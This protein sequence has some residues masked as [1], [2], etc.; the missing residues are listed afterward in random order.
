[1][2]DTLDLELE[3]AL[4]N[5]FVR[6]EPGDWAAV[7]ARAGRRR[8]LRSVRVA[9]VVAAAMLL[10]ATQALGVTPGVGSLFGTSAPKPVRSVFA[11]GFLG[12]DVDASTIRL[13][14]Q[15]RLQDGSLLRLWTAHRR[16]PGS[17][18]MQFEVGSRSTRTVGCGSVRPGTV[19]TWLMGSVAPGLPS[20]HESY[21]LGGVAPSAAS[22]VRLG[23]ADGKVRLARVV[24]GAWVVEI[25]WAQRRY[26]HDL[27]TIQV[28]DAHGTPI[29]TQHRPAA[30][31][32]SQAVAPY[33]TVAHFAGRPLR[34]ANGS[35]G[36]VCV[37]FRRADGIGVNTCAEAVSGAGAWFLR[38]GPPGETGRLVL[39]GF[40][41]R[42]AVAARI[43][44]EDGH[45]LVGRR[46]HGVFAIEL[47]RTFASRPARLAFLAAEARAIGTL[48]LRGPAHG[49]YE[50][51]WHGALYTRVSIGRMNSLNY[52]VGPLEWP[53][54]HI[55]PHG[56]RG[57][58]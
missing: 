36:A 1:M 10:V 57:G 35:N 22:R 28:L 34:T 15:V 38:L 4:R 2:T 27:T 13:G 5:V 53:D 33:V 52:T 20:P 41:P 40:L 6:D 56:T 31:R 29:A 47:P 51:A 37:D 43:T 19:G 16:A 11:R 3:A 17:T 21:A 26:D 12:K 32:P 45:T 54:G 30:K 25:P 24:R 9:A 50:P 8:K 42:R 18:C 58:G 55:T 46:T 14:A 44:F 23:F 49:L 48:S 7:Q 39:F